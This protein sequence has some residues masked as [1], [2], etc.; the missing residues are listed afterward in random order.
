MSIE[1]FTTYTVVEPDTIFTVTASKSAFADMDRDI[2]AYLWKDYGAGYF[3]D[4][5]HRLEIKFTAAVHASTWWCWLITNAVD[6]GYNANGIKLMPS[7]SSTEKKYR[8]DAREG[9][10]YGTLIDNTGYIFSLNTVYYLTVEREGTT[11]TC[12]IRSGS[13]EGTLVDT[14]T[15]TCGTTTYQYIE[16]TASHNTASSNYDSDGYVENLRFDI[17]VAPVG[18]LSLTDAVRFDT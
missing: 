13:H 18:K 12:Y 3:G 2:D 7:Y 16:V 9:A 11:F 14:I 10:E 4:F 1:D 17:P 8:I 15:G 5:G 6:D